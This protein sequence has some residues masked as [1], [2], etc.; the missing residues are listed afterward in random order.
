MRCR[1]RSRRRT[2]AASCPALSA[3][4]MIG[5]PC[6]SSAQTKCTLVAAHALEAHPDVGL[7]VLHHVADVERRVRVRQRGRDEELAGHGATGRE[8][9]ILGTLCQNPGRA[10]ARTRR[11]RVEP[12]AT[13]TARIRDGQESGSHR[14]RRRGDRR[15]RARRQC[16]RLGLSHRRAA[17]RVGGGAA[18]QRAAARARQRALAGQGR[19]ERPARLRDHRPVRSTS[20]RTAPP[21]RRSRRRSTRSSGWRATTRCSGG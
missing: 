20:R 21:S 6:A 12:V 10:C 15:R 18:Q 2:A 3:A 14:H 11:S 1:R 8:P 4:I 17:R 5:A 9:V 19:R 16:R 7:D 13:R